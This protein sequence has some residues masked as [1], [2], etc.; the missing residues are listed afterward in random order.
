MSLS[1]VLTGVALAAVA[2]TGLAP[3]YAQTDAG[4]SEAAAPPTKANIRKED[5]AL[6]K[7]I[8]HTLTKTKH[9]VSSGI[10][11]LVRPG[12]KVT[13]EGTAPNQKQIDLAGKTVE[14]V[15]G[16][17]SVTNNLQVYTEGN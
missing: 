5:R 6:E 16:V 13:L 11:I 15:S 4:S 7:Q 8:R 10:N 2:F 17:T 3:V 12:G 14:G 1:K 9:L